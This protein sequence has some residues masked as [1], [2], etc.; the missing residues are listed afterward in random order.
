MFEMIKIPNTTNMLLWRPFLILYLERVPEGQWGRNA[1]W[2]PK[3]DAFSEG[4]CR[5]LVAEKGAKHSPRSAKQPTVAKRRQASVALGRFP[6][7]VTIIPCGMVCHK[8]S[9]VP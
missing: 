4:P 3:K 5:M 9:N 7:C 8:R 6:L 1:L 2:N